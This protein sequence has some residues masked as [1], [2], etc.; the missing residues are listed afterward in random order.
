[1]PGGQAL[2]LDAGAAAGDAGDMDTALAFQQLGY[3]A[4]AGVLDVLGG[5]ELYIDRAV[6]DPVFGPGAG[7]H[8]GVQHLRRV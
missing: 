7:D 2:D 5:D 1:M 8:D 6:A 3:I 4:G